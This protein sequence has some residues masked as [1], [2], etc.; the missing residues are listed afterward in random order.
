[1]PSVYSPTF[2]TKKEE[3]FKEEVL[4]PLNTNKNSFLQLEAS[5]NMP[6]TDI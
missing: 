4:D 2:A 6:E 3:C 1:M 5:K